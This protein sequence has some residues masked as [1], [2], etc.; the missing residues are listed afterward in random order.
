MQFFIAKFIPEDN[1][2]YFTKNDR[3]N[4]TIET[5]NTIKTQHI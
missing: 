4:I 1:L 2:K 5:I 3:G